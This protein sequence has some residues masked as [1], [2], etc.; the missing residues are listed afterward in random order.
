M[1]YERIFAV[2]QQGYCVSRWVISFVEW[3]QTGCKWRNRDETLCR[4]LMTKRDKRA[5]T[6]CEAETP[7]HCAR[8]FPPSSCQPTC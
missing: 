3:V 4:H 8:R 7:L 6:G 5:G 2:Q 1:R